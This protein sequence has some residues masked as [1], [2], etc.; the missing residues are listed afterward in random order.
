MDNFTLI[1]RILR[2]LEK[3][4]KNAEFDEDN[5]TPEYFGVGDEFFKRTLKMLYDRGFFSELVVK[6]GADGYYSISGGNPLITLSGL[7]YLHGNEFMRKE[8]AK[9]K[10]VK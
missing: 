5:F 9:A 2:F 7:E 6:Q 8:A 4:S 3:S 1:Y 10:G